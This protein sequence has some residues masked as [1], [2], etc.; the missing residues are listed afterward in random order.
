M[1]VRHGIVVAGVGA[2][3]FG[4]THVGALKSK[5]ASDLGCDADEVDVVNGG[6]TRDVECR[7][8]RATYH[9]GNGHWTRQDKPSTEAASPTPAA[10]PS[11]PPRKEEWQ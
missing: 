7:G 10:P 4:C 3:L 1:N 8:R 6:Y 2:L 11:P 9:W 5:A